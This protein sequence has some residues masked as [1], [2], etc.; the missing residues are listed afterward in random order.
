MFNDYAAINKILKDL[1]NIIAYCIECSE[2]TNN[3]NAREL[4]Q[5][6]RNE[7][8]CIQHDVATSDWDEEEDEDEELENEDE[9]E[10]E[11]EE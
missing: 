11:E 3:E 8:E 1:S 9:D 10:D 7:L 4:Y 2:Q 6:I 5:D